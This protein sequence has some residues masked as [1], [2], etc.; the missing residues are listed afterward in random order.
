MITIRRADERGH[1]EID[2]LDS[3]HTFSF[4]D[5]YDPDNMGFGVLR[6]INDDRV[7][8][9]KGFGTHGHRDMEIITYILQGELQHKDSMGNGSI[10]RPGDVQRMTAGTG[11]M[12]SEF[13]PSQDSVVWLL[14]IWILP[15]RQGLTPGYEQR[16]YPL[17]QRKDTLKLVASRDGADGS[18]K[19]NQDARLF[20]AVLEPDRQIHHE[21][22]AGRRSWLHVARGGVSLQGEPLCEGDG[23]AIT[24]GP[25]LTIRA[26]AAS[27][28]LL[29]DLP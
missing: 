4:G 1:T 8:P 15:E 21:G 27:E 17:A 6:V 7:R 9:G 23:A 3:Y 25:R 18:V 28:I 19:I 22:A 10:I 29:F 14:Q 20:A 24:G 16:T 26:D 12:H 2:W 5:Y 13:N 11:V